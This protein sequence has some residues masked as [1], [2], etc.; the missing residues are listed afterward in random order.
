[1]NYMYLT[2]DVV[3]AAISRAPQVSLQSA[4]NARALFERSSHLS[5]DQKGNLQSN[6][7]S[8]LEIA[9]EVIKQQAYH[10]GDIAGY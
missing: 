1:M 10:F 8:L 3:W 2:L 9:N 7:R 6:T 5:V 4:G